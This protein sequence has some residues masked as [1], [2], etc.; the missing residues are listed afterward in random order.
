M[1]SEI[2]VSSKLLVAVEMLARIRFFVAVRPQMSLE[3]APL[4]E[5]LVADV[6]FVWGTLVVDHLVNGQ[7]ARL[8]E[9]LAALA[10]LKWLFVRV[11]EAMVAQ[12]VLPPEGLVA[13]V[14]LIGSLVGVRS[15]VDQEVVGFGELTLAES[16]YEFCSEDRFGCGRKIY[17]S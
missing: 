2:A 11:D 13:D 15:L 8:T 5:D 9:A 17:R 4:V 7:R 1:S 16:A 6:A 12:M 3:V 10:A 14:T